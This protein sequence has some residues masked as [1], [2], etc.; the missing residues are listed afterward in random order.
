MS[1]YIALIRRGYIGMLVMGF[2]M[3]GA[4]GSGLYG[5]QEGPKDA[6]ETRK[7]ADGTISKMAALAN[8]QHGYVVGTGDVLRVNVWREPELS[9]TVVVRPDGKI[10]LP[11][12]DEVQVSGLTPRQI[13]ELLQEKWKSFLTTPQVTIGVSEIH[14]RMVYITG[15]VI[16]AGAYPL[17]NRITVLQLIARAGQLC[18]R[19]QVV[20]FHWALSSRFTRSTR[21][22]VSAD[23]EFGTS[24]LTGSR[25]RDS[26]VTGLNQGIGRAVD[27]GFDL[28]YLRTA[29]TARVAQ[30][31][32]FQGYLAT[33][34]VRWR[35][36]RG[37][38]AF[39]PAGRCCGSTPRPGATLPQ[40]Q[41]KA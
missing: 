14:S 35:I 6:K 25:W 22:Y 29:Q 23:R 3:S 7:A 40:N 28:G 36:A 1:G 27:F 15:E 17:L 41:R 21:G 34:N 26:V 32:L 8:G 37:W 2:L 13:Q 19:K 10:S 33:A 12:V 20:N 4:A 9:Q 11:L 30:S 38:P 16:K 18:A 5:Q 31:V 24:Y 39:N